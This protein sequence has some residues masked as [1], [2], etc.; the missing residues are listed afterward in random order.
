MIS[1]QLEGSL[2][3]GLQANNMIIAP[4]CYKKIILATISHI[5][6]S[7]KEQALR[8]LVRRLLPTDGA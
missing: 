3:T 1:R 2:S 6:W 4:H 8:G 5:D 7:E